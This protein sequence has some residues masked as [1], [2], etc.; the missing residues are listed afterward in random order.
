MASIPIEERHKGSFRHT[1]RKTF[2]NCHGHPNPSFDPEDWVAS[3]KSCA[4]P[5]SFGRADY[6]PGV[7]RTS[8]K[9][10]IAELELDQFK[11][12]MAQAGRDSSGRACWSRRRCRG[13]W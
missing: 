2:A 7:T 12:L 8:I 3:A 1:N 5:P 11:V 9:R 6:H 13:S 4:R 10:L